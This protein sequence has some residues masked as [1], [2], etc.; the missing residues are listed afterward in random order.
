MNRILLASFLLLATVC[1]SVLAVGTAFTY[2]GQ[3]SVSGSPADGPYDFEFRLFDVLSGGTPIGG[4]VLSAEDLGVVDG[5]FTVELDFGLSPFDGSDLWLELRVRDG[6]DTGGHTILAPRQ[7]LTAVPYAVHADFV[8]A[9]TVGAVEINPAEVQQRIVGGC[10]ADQSISAIAQDG[11]VTCVSDSGDISAVNAGTGLSGGGTSGA[12]ELAAD[13]AYLQRRVVGACPAGQAIRAVAA[14]GTVTCVPAEAG[15]ITEVIA[16]VGLTGGGTSGT[17]TVSAD[18]SASIQNQTAAVQSGSWW[19]DGTMRMGSQDGTD[20]PAFRPI[21]VRQARTTNPTAGAV[22]ARS[23]GILLQRDGSSTGLR[24][25][26]LNTNNK[27]IACTG[28]TNTGASVGFASN[29]TTI[30][31]TQVF[32]DAQ[33]VVHYEC[34][35]GYYFSS[36]AHHTRVS[37][38]RFN[39][40]FY[41]LGFIQSTYNQ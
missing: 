37:M 18:P 7:R 39:T 26:S 17:V 22:V 23:E 8:A 11:T 9:G 19:I 30:G 6:S 25:E 33:N 29:L 38:T 13:T 12:V 15:D 32:T 21:I 5:T 2:Q 34:S 31:I 14:N 1:S 4:T 41:W 3:L 28:V 27:S 24:V 35:F 40:D 36:N 10:A 16:G 20:L